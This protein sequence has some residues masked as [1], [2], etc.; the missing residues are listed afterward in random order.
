MIS[1]E[2]GRLSKFYS[3]IDE[4]NS[5]SASTKTSKVPEMT[6]GAI[7]GKITFRNATRQYEDETKQKRAQ[8]RLFCHAEIVHIKGVNIDSFALDASQHTLVRIKLNG[9]G[10]CE[11]TEA[12][13][14]SFVRHVHHPN[15]FLLTGHFKSDGNEKLERPRDV[16]LL[17][18]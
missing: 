14:G 16:F 9:G 17:N 7:I 4:T 12:L 15:L 2:I 8:C 1:T 13:C 3:R 11:W 5:P 18:F 10:H 6:P